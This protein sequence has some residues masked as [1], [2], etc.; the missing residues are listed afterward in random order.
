M[1]EESQLMRTLSRILGIVIAVLCGSTPPLAAQFTKEYRVEEISDGVLAVIWEDIGGYP[2]EGNH[3]IVINDEDVL[4]VDANRTPGLADT[5][6]GI[7]RAH[8]DKP[9][10]W[11]VNTH[12]HADH[13]Q[14]NWAYR[15]AYPGVE[16]VGH[17]ATVAGIDTVLVPYV[18]GIHSDLAE[19]RNTIAAQDTASVPDSAARAAATGRLPGLERESRLYDAVTL[20]RPTLLVTDSIVIRRGSR[21][22]RIIHPGP[23]NT[24]GD[25][26]VHLP[27]EGI[28]AVGDL[29]TRPFPFIGYDS[30]GSWAR[31]LDD[32][33]ARKPSAVLPGHGELMRSF[34]Y[35]QLFRD[36]MADVSDQ[37]REA[38][39][40]GVPEAEIS[41]GV[42][43]ERHWRVFADGNDQRFT[44]FATR[45]QAAL[46]ARAL[47][48]AR[49]G[50]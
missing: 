42:D 10:R 12:W 30:P 4:V 43:L 37:V 50:G 9:V 35:V 17:P 27:Q 34:E 14:G 22:I 39:A 36:L 23:A 8:T 5:V 45:F 48:E 20:Q 25:L 3:L 46:V 11:V 38:V 26:I 16:I 32:V 6:I 18:D 47:R 19:A 40:A 49:G 15:T 7:V 24:T 21:D 2:V 29:V 1:I 28:V 13:V 41:D 33:L 44:A 31:A